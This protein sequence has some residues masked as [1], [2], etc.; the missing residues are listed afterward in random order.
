VVLC[1]GAH[2]VALV[3]FA[4][5]PLRFRHTSAF[6]DD[7]T[8]VLEGEAHRYGITM[9]VDNNS[10]GDGA[11]VL[12]CVGSLQPSSPCGDCLC[13]GVRGW[14]RSC[15]RC[16]SHTAPTVLSVLGDATALIPIIRYEVRLSK[17]LECGGAY[18]KLLDAANMPDDGNVVRVQCGG[19]I[20]GEATCAC[21]CTHNVCNG[22]GIQP[23]SSQH[24]HRP[25]CRRRTLRTSSCSARTS[26]ARTTRCVV[27]QHSNKMG[28]WNAR[29]T[30]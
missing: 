20:D 23:V 12:Q 16:V 26:A 2:P 15:W 6:S 21:A 7:Q 24:Q 25:P 11:L 8:L 30:S 3:P 4:V 19:W 17:G 10:D 18:L 14:V 5:L 13:T 1:T 28:G 22:M 29:P 9:K 27:R